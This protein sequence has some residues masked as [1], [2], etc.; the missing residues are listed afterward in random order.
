MPDCEYVSAD[1]IL[2]EI[3]RLVPPTEPGNVVLASSIPP[4]LTPADIPLSALDVPMYQVD[5]VLRRTPALQLTREAR[6]AASN[7]L[8]T[9]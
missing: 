3:R 9:V 6:T 8:E 7:K 5:A 1:E 2:A 4:A